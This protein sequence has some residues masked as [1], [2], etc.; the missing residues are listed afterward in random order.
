[1][2][3]KWVKED[4]YFIT[5]CEKCGCKKKNKKRPY[6]AKYCTPCGNAVGGKLTSAKNDYKSKERNDKISKGKKEWWATQDTSI[7]NEWLSDYRGS[8]AHIA[9]CKSN[10]KKATKASWGKTQSK[11]EREYEAY[12]KKNGIQYETQYYVCQYPFDFYLPKSNLLVEIDGE[13]FHPLT[14]DDCV[15]PMQHHNYKRDKLKTQVA[16]DN[17]YDLKR[18]R[19]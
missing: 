12:L 14:E 2:N 17:G 13:F 11:P 19:V 6:G 15:Y 10:Q 3:R 9:M 1:M 8:D 16:I 7:I 18:I 5:Y 4:G